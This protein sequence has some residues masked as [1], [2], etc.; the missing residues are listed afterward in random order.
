MTCTLFAMRRI[1][2]LNTVDEKCIQAY[3]AYKALKQD[4]AIFNMS[5]ANCFDNLLTLGNR[6]IKTFNINLEKAINGN[7]SYIMFIT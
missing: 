2:Y 3:D 5:S 4:L 7:L 1:A 6:L